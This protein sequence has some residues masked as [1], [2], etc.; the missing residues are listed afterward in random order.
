ME[1]KMLM[2]ELARGMEILPGLV[3]GVSQAEAQ[4][5]PNPESRSFLEAV[6][7]LYDEEKEDFRVRLE[8]MLYH[9]RDP[10]PPIRPDEWVTERHYNEQDLAETVEKF[11]AERRKS[12]EWLRGLKKPDWTIECPTPFGILLKSGDML[13]AWVEHDALHMRQLVELRHE[14]I[15]RMAAPYTVKYAGD[16]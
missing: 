10:W 7:H 1:P 8:I 13:S 3:A 2:D 12:L 9:P 6:Y 14:R 11:K 15:L 5:K 4:I 16:W